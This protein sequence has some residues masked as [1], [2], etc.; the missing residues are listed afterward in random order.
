[1]W[2]KFMYWIGTSSP[3]KKTN[4]VGAEAS[5][6]FQKN[7]EMT[8][9]EDKNKIDTKKSSNRQD[10]VHE[11]LWQ[12]SRKRE[13]LAYILRQGLQVSEWAEQGGPGGTGG[14]IEWKKWEGLSGWPDVPKGGAWGWMWLCRRKIEARNRQW[15]ERNSQFS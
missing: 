9:K 2:C 12:S 11:V 6:Q 13:W 15:D 8:G 3:E 4:Q 1:M 10:G 7:K 14:N 5:K